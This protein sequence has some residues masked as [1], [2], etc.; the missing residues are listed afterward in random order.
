MTKGKFYCG[1]ATGFL[2]GMMFLLLLMI[3]ISNARARDN[4]QWAQVDPKV[5]DWIKG[6]RDGKGLSCCDE[7]DA[8]EVE[9]WDIQ[10]GKYRVRIQGAWL[11]VP[12]V[13]VLNVPNLL[14]YAKAWVYSENGQPKIRCF[15]VGSL[16]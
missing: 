8:A 9:M 13:A 1:L 5:R 15:I 4:G 2:A 11:D 3:L 16:S 14:G 12:P 7:G 6:L 10:D